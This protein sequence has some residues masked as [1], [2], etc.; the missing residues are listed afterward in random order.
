MKTK[1]LITVE[2][3]DDAIRRV[4]TPIAAGLPPEAI[5]GDINR[6]LRLWASSNPYGLHDPEH[7]SL[8]L[9]ISGH[10]DPIDERNTH[11]ALARDLMNMSRDLATLANAIQ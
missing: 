9:A 4:I 7:L 5:L 1:I 2:I 8:K 3:D 11:A 6:E 10:A